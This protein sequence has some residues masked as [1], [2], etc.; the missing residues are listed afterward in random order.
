MSTRSPNKSVQSRKRAESVA[1]EAEDDVWVWGVIFTA[2][3]ITALCLATLFSVGT[4][5]G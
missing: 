4:G 1:V 3:A 2:S 5:A